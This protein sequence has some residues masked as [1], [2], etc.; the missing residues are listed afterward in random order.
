MASRYDVA[1]LGGGHNGLVA[2]CYLGM[3]GKKVLVL[4]A[5]PEEGGAAV[6][7]SP[8]PGFDVKLSRYAYLVSLFPDRIIKELGLNLTTLS[9]R[10][11][12][13]TPYIASN[14]HQGLHV[15]RVW[16]PETEDS[17]SLLTGDRTEA[18]QW[19]TFYN[20]LSAMARKLAPTLLEPLASRSEVRSLVGMDDV[21]RMVFERPIGE[22]LL[23]QFRSDIVR[24]VILTDALIGTHASAYE[25]QANRCL[26]YHVM[27]N[28]NGEWK[29]PKGG[30]GVLVAELKRVALANG[31]EI[32]TQARV[33][34]VHSGKSGVE[35]STDD[36]GH[37]HAD[38]LL[39]NAA[40][41][42]LAKMMGKPVPEAR[43][44]CQTKINLL[45]ARLPRF[46]SGVDSQTALSGT[47]HL[48]EGFQQ[49]EDAYEESRRGSLPR[50]LPFE[51]YCHSLTDP[52]IMS[53]DMQYKGIHTL[54]MFALHTPARLFDGRNREMGRTVCE[55]AFA[56]LNEH[57]VDPIES[58]L[59]RMPGGD[60]C[61]E[62]KTPLDL[63]TN[64][65][66]PRGNIFHNDLH[67]PFLEERR[68]G[69][70]GV[71][72]EDPRILICGSGAIR[73][74]GVSG[75]PGHNAAMAVLNGPRP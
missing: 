10:M 67:F 59:A 30:M 69:V 3:A 6:S 8:F 53:R 58:C 31:V 52:S 27:G 34:D 21:W 11:S 26:L 51:M 40:P 37:F 46:R 49:L 7:A 1:I 36:G 2:A 62:I 16:D 44:G 14:R 64:L 63:E 28:G 66:L 50:E 42:V 60:P 22:T 57:L 13:Y 17:F 65:G 73:G 56:A 32:R 19:R 38:R 45:L 9:R 47:L 25:M 20:G 55:K 68:E 5:G 29:V 74:G 75:I 39:C 61:I 41:Q 23:Q 18:R 35:L 43:E 48:Q 72:T 54:T 4:E 70:W 12:S 24:G 71:E 15:A 33:I